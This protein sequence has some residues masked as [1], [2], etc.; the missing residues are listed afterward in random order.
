MR[1]IFENLHENLFLLRTAEAIASGR[2]PWPAKD[3]N[4]LEY[5]LANEKK[6]Y[7]YINEKGSWFANGK[8]RFLNNKFTRIAE[9]YA[10]CKINKISW[11]KIVILKKEDIREDDVLITY[12]YSLGDNTNHGLDGVHC[13]KV[14]DMNHFYAR[15]PQF[16]FLPN[17]DCLVCEGDIF[18][19]SKLLNDA[20]CYSENQY[21]NIIKPYAFRKRFVRKIPFCKRKNK[22]VATGTCKVL[23]EAR[24]RKLKNIYHVNCLHPARLNIYRHREEWSAY[25]DSK[26]SLWPDDELEKEDIKKG[27]A[28]FKLVRE[29]K[30]KYALKYLGQKKYYSFDMADLYNDYKMAII[31]EEVVGSPA[32]GFVEAM[33]CGCAFIGLGNGMYEKFGMKSGVHYIGYDGSS[34]DMLKKISYYQHHEKEL[35]EIAMNGYLFATENFNGETVAQNYHRQICSLAK[36][37]M[38]KK[39]NG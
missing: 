7:I 19:A 36:E 33:A 5:Y 12:I 11:K 35:E 15:I 18:S 3:W 21:D 8:Y 22:A 9:C 29:L 20:K 27:A 28:F 16:R 1:I 4:I 30:N 37:H 17:F 23:S 14:L 6:I 13:Y 2:K 32:V 38:K 26:I 10:I 25:I 39:N 34:E 24:Y 31:G